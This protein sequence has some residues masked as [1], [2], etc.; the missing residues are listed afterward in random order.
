VSVAAVDDVSSQGSCLEVPLE[1][2]REPREKGGGAENG[3]GG[4]VAVVPRRRAQGGEGEEGSTK[5]K[6][7]ILLPRSD[8]REKRRKGLGWA[9]IGRAHSLT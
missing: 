5:W 1:D 6:K 3:E 4:L 2:F 9:E 7:P 8:E